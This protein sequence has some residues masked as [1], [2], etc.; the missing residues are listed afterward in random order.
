MNK[1]FLNTIR[2]YNMIQEKDRI[3]VALS[4]GAD[5]VLL[6]R[7]L[8]ELKNEIDF[9]LQAAHV[10]HN[11]RDE[12]KDDENFVRKI[13]KDKNIELH[14]LSADVKT[15]AKENKIGLE[16]AGREIRYKFFEKLIKENN[17]K[18][19]TAHNLN[20]RAETLLLNLVRGCGISGLKS[21]PYVR[22]NY[23]RPIL[24]LS[25]EEIEKFCKENNFDY[26]DDKTNFE[27]DYNRNKIR[28]NV[29]P[30][31]LKINPSLL[32]VFKRNFE[33]FQ[34]VDAYLE[35]EANKLK[36]EALSD[37]KYKIDII[38][39]YDDIVIYKFLSNIIFENLKKEPEK[40]HIDAV[41]KLLN[42]EKTIDLPGGRIKSYNNSLYFPKNINA[43]ETKSVDFGNNKVSKNKAL[44]LNRIKKT[45]AQLSLNQMNRYIDF[46]KVKFPIYVRSRKPKDRL[47][48]APRNV[49]KSLK[50]LF[51]ENKIPVEN[52]DEIV[53][54]F[55]S[56]DNLIFAEKIGV[57]ELV[58]ID[59]DTTEMIEIKFEVLNG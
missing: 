56:D 24:D 7:L 34:Q 20:D 2:K 51:L 30:E 32:K 11:L 3:I 23:I 1:I 10:N 33:N 40:I 59:S 16:Q 55:D 4:G 48:I 35:K 36:K 8:N 38:N 5:S 50:Q 17:A 31:L 9:D 37:G 18:I 54:L 22:N 14:V 6:F 58:K 47:K 15:F 45:K 25:R 57:S 29:I 39:K 53:L 42:E 41:M 19:A 49:T 12:A 44:I 46:E 26:R 28:L 21:I 13:C 27:T 52:R 43:I